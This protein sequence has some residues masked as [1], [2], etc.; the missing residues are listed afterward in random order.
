MQKQDVQ[1]LLLYM[2]KKIEQSHFKRH[3]KI[4]SIF[5]DI[6]R[7]NKVILNLTNTKG[8]SFDIRGKVGVSGNAKKR[9]VLFSVGKVSTTSQNLKAQF[10]QIS[11]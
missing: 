8:F 3:K 11:V 4:L 10:Q 5:F 1:I 6:L 7:K 2:K 9:H